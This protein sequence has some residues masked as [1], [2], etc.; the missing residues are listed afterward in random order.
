MINNSRQI[1]NRNFII[2]IV[3]YIIAVFVGKI[4]FEI[5]NTSQAA[6]F[7]LLCLIVSYILAL[8]A[9]RRT[10]LLA[11]QLIFII[12][13]LAFPLGYTVFF[14]NT[15]IS[16]GLLK[17]RTT[18][19]LVLASWFLAI[20]NLKM[21][22]KSILTIPLFIPFLCIFL[23]Y[24]IGFIV[25]GVKEGRGLLFIR[26]PFQY[27][28]FFI[29]IAS[30]E[31]TWNNINKILKIIIL[32]FLFMEFI[33]VFHFFTEKGS[34]FLEGWRR[35]G[36]YYLWPV[37][38]F[39]PLIHKLSHSKINSKTFNFILLIVFLLGVVFIGI[40]V[41]KSLY[42]T[43]ILAILFSLMMTAYTGRK[44]SLGRNTVYLIAVIFFLLIIM[45]A[46]IYLLGI[47]TS[48]ISLLGKRWEW[49]LIEIGLREPQIGALPNIRRRVELEMFIDG[50]KQ[51]LFLGF[52]P[53]N[54]VALKLMGDQ[55]ISFYG[56]EIHAYNYVHSFAVTAL[57]DV[58]ILGL[59]A[60][61]LIP[62]CLIIYVKRFKIYLSSGYQNELFILVLSIGFVTFVCMMLLDLARCV[63]G[64]FQIGII[65]GLIS[66]TISHINNNYRRAF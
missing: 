55:M 36:A 46:I 58:G 11:L 5:D 2:I 8:V 4:I 30:L 38:A 31:P 66:L 57:Y 63:F 45:E 43:V 42:G 64:S 17:I 7:V 23:V 62:L 65:F 10:N 27:L 20:Y 34:S 59:C 54:K 18:D 44:I 28:S 16:K 39:L 24:L 26:L 3:S 40:S 50:I 49:F 51:G 41:S 25:F 32:S 53:S 56:Y 48:Y 33:S 12:A 19:V 47:E 15:I 21:Q 37:C 13:L 35:V 52:G 60:Y 14:F 9:T 29:L 1:L 6:R 61:S 22:R